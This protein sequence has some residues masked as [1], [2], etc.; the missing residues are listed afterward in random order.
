MSPFLVY[1][2]MQMDDIKGCLLFVI[3]ACIVLGILA[4]VIASNCYQDDE[5]AAL[6]KWIKRAFAGVCVCIVCMGLLPS[7]KTIAAMAIIPAV[8]QSENFKALP[9]D[10]LTFLR[11]I[12]KEH[13]ARAEQL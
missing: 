3:L 12:I 1:I 5:Q 6:K 11:S 4:G 8:T 7:T 2:A 10:V 13:S 9:E